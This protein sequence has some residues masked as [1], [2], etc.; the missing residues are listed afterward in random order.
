MRSGWLRWA[1]DG[2]FIVAALLVQQVDSWFCVKV[3]SH[4]KVRSSA[5]EFL[6]L[7]CNW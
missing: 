3:L 4:K 7:S 6:E 5:G 2:H 1:P